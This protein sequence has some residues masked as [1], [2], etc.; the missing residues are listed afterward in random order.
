MKKLDDQITRFR[1]DYFQVTGGRA[2]GF[3]CPITLEDVAVDRLCAGHILNDALGAASSKKV[4]QFRDV[5]HYFGTTIEPDLIDFL[6]FS[7]M[8]VEER[9]R[10]AKRFSIKLD[11]KTYEV[12][13]AGPDAAKKFS[14][15]RDCG[16]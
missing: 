1:E 14:K 9:L 13:R 5:D 10:K 8:S 2:K 7:K 6:N 3:V 16:S 12:F 15:S 11:G 4:I